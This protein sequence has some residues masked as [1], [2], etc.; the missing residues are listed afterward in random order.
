MWGFRDARPVPLIS[1][2]PTHKLACYRIGH[3]LSIPQK[4]PGSTPVAVLY[5]HRNTIISHT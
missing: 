5:Y 3:R 1:C 2:F 4:L